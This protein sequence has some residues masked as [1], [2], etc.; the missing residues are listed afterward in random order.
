MHLPDGASVMIFQLKTYS[1]QYF[2][3]K[4]EGNQ[5]LWHTVCRIR[6]VTA[7]HPGNSM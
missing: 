2:I 7:I 6:Y 3:N 4:K 1:F 5:G